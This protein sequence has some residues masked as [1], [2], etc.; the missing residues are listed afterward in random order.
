MFFYWNKEETNHELYMSIEV[1]FSY[2]N[3]YNIIN[4]EHLLFLQAL[5]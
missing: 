1:Y 2:F 5:F 4:S 3:K